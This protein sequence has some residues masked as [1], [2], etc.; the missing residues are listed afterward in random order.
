MRALILL[1]LVGC[2]DSGPRCS[3]DPGSID[4]GEVEVRRGISKTI[5]LRNGLATHQQLTILP[6]SPP[7]E[8]TP[9]AQVFLPAN[10]ST[11]I[12]VF[13][14][15]TDGLLHH[16]ELVMSSEDGACAVTVPLRGLGSGVL[17]AN[18]SRMEFV[19]SKGE[20]QT[21]DVFIENGRRV[22]LN[23]D[24]LSMGPIT[25]SLPE[26]RQIPAGGSLRVQVTARMETWQRLS[27]GVDVFSA[28]ETFR[29][30][31]ELIPST[32][33]VE[34][35]PA[36]ID[37]PTV[38]MDLSSAPKGFVDR[39]VRIRNAGN[40]GDPSAPAL[41]IEGLFLGSSSAL[42][43]VEINGPNPVLGENESTQFSIR[44]TP[45]SL[46]PRAFDFHLKSNVDTVTVPLTT[47]SVFMPPCQME[48]LPADRVA[49]QP[50]ADGGVEGMVSL[51]NS[52]DTDCTVDGVRLT[53]WT[54]NG[55]SI[56]GVPSEQFKMLP[57]EQRQFTISG[58]QQQPDAGTIGAFGFHVFQTRSDIRWL[59]LDAP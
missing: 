44:I 6:V 21:R 11:P 48:V 23:L 30:Q 26:G 1:A 54:P 25:V 37:I 34:V 40:S 55:F 20:T 45:K 19:L 49:L 35:I 12:D 33:R 51:T 58:P 17:R 36:T 43:D 52:G 7:F 13:F 4:F 24:V 50:L 53:S 46:G 42:D 8:V 10:A 3:T 27:A 47:R 16:E 31:I 29:I 39:L 32:P 59:A 15:P 38:A 41:I 2:A 57:Q 18:A 5:V 14:G 22:P 9:R 56:S 28:F